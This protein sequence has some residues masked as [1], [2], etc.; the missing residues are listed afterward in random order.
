MAHTAIY[1]SGQ[2]SSNFKLLSA[3]GGR[4]ERTEFNGFKINFNSKKEAVKAIRNAYNKLIQDEP[5]CKNKIGGIRTNKTRTELLYD[6]SK[7]IIK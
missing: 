7:A 2:I 5:E 3:I 1:I 6:A 4:H